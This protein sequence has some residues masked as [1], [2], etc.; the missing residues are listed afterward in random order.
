MATRIRNEQNWVSDG[1]DS[2]DIE[3]F[4]GDFAALLRAKIEKGARFLS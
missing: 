2:L 1:A 3:D 4:D